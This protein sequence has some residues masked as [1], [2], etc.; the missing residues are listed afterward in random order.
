MVFK[1]F[2]VFFFEVFQ[3]YISSVSTAFRRMLQ[4][5]YL[6]VLKVDQVCDI[7]PPHLLLHHLSRRRQAIHTTLLLGPSESEALLLLLGRRQACMERETE[8]STRASGVHLDASTTDNLI[9]KQKEKK[10]TRDSSVLSKPSSLGVY[11]HIFI[12]AAS[13][14]HCVPACAR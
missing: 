13:T 8:C 5:L 2:H 3:K 6:D 12:H 14:M 7:S 11:Y 1:C 10:G 9:N 4:L